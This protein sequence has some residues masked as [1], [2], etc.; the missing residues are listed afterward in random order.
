V[1][2]TPLFV[3]FCK[4]GGETMARKKVQKPQSE[5]LECLKCKRQLADSNYYMNENELFSTQKSVICKKCLN[6]YI[7]EKDSVGYLDRVKMVLAILNKPLIMDLWISRG[8]DWTKYIPQLSSF[9]QYR[10][11]TFADSD[12]NASNQQ[13]VYKTVDKDNIELDIKNNN[14]LFTTEELYELQE[15]WGR[16]LNQDEYYFLTNEYQRLLNSYECDSYAMELLFQEAAQQRL[17][18]KKRREKGDSVDKELKTLQDLLGSANIKPAQET[19]ANAVEQAT[20]GT[21]IKKYENEKP[22]PEPDEAWK[23]VDGVRKYVNVWF[24]GHLSKMLGIKN[25][26]SKEYDEEINKYKVE[27]PEFEEDSDKGVV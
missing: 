26:H 12:F 3:L 1:L 9:P 15:F 23:D 14:P 22:I 10:G 7:G 13:I 17:T 11:K 8:S 20:F 19:G 24:L 25:E 27:A 16:G 21:L 2:I 6:D 5:K 18:I 4:K